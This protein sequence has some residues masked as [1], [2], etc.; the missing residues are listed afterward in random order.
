MPSGTSPVTGSIPAVPEQKT[1]PPATMAWLYG[2][3]AAGASSVCTLCRF[4]GSPEVVGVGPGERRSRRPPARTARGT[5]A[6]PR[7]GYRGESDT[8]RVHNDVHGVVGVR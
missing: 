7:T 6:T 2:P 4:I 3:S 1:N 8:R 5:A